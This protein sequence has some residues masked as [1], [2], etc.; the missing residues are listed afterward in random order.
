M[1][2]VIYIQNGVLA[3][4][5]KTK[6]KSFLYSMRLWLVVAL[7]AVTI[8][9]LFIMRLVA[10]EN[11][12][13]QLRARRMD[14]LSNYSL[15]LSNQIVRSNYFKGDNMDTVHSD[16]NQSAS[17]YNGRILIIDSKYM[18]V[19]DTYSTLDHMTSI[20]PET[21]KA[22]GGE[23]VKKYNKEDGMMEL[24]VPITT[25]DKSK[26][27]GVILFY[28]SISDILKTCDSIGQSYNGITTA[29]VCLFIF[30]SLIIA[31]LFT[32][33]LKRVANSIDRMAEGHFDEDIHLRGFSEI[34]TISDSFNTMLG[35]L[36]KLENSRQEFVSNVSHELKTPI[37]SI[38]VLADSLNMQEDVPN[39]VYKEFMQDIV[40]EID[41]EN[42]IINDLLSLVKM[43]KAVAELNVSLVNIND[44]LEMILKRLRP[45]AAKR[46]I[47]LVF[48]SFRPVSAECDEVK[49]NLA[50]TNLVENGIK[51]N[52]AGGWVKV[53]LDADHKY[54]YVKVADSGIGIPKEYQDQIFERF[55]RVD[56]ARSRETGGTG[57]GLAITKNVILMHSGA[58]KVLSKEDE[59]STFVVRIPIK[60][61]SEG[62]NGGAKN[63]KE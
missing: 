30:L 17:M 34:K 59:G 57:L 26:V 14:E 63:E 47:E 45:I 24:A 1:S 22:M 3:I 28:S 2:H 25:E 6:K 48:E 39:E 15:I 16:M 21:I 33:P 37:T 46:N 31:N 62:M 41:R 18:I 42:Q 29:L 44:M 55:Y 38:K 49:I 19:K 56:K 5:S 52:V 8:S 58:I 51:Y 27:L 10:L 13:A 11:I 32:K 35:K 53:S 4:S 12:E 50:F 7:I 43:D 23:S 61:L 60:H 9:P 20:S 40:V 36:R 54:F